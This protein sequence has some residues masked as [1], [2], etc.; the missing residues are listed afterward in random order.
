MIFQAKVS[1]AYNY[2]IAKNKLKLVPINN[3]TKFNYMYVKPNDYNIEAIAFIGS[4]PDELAK[5]L[6]VDY[7][8]MFR[9]SFVPIIEKMFQISKWI[10]EKD[11]IIIEK[12]GMFNF[13][14]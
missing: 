6:E 11:S 8:T 3:N 1:L 5:I 14:G 7:E 10:G 9:K 13:F 12:S 2:L 4:W